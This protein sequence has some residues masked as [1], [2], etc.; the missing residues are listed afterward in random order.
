V[1][2]MRVL[3]LLS[4]LLT[5]PATAATLRPMGTLSAPVVLLSDLFDDAGE[6]AARVLGPGPAPGGRIVVEAAQLA[7]IARQFGV[8]WKPASRADRAVLERPGKPLPR[9]A[10]VAALEA[11]LVS[12][13]VPAESEIEVP[14]VSLPLIPF[15]SQLRPVVTQLDHDSVSGLFSATLSIGGTEM[16]VAQVRVNGRVHETVEVTVPVR[17]VQPGEVLRAEDLRPLRLRATRIHA[18]VARTAEEA[19]G[20]SPRSPLQPGQPIRQ[21]DL[22]TPPAVRKGETVQM[23]LNGGGLSLLAQA[24]ALESGAPGERVRVLNPSS[25]AVLEATVIGPER[26]R[27]NPDSMP[28]VPPGGWRGALR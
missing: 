17:R 1:I 11:A 6:N 15:E 10:M 9:E 4:L 22:S 12:A 25:R 18:E 16:A 3:F 20:Q 24:T 5:L 23:V 7:A 8:A 26:V 27:V 19:I 21:A 13:G 2:A 14:A 28:I